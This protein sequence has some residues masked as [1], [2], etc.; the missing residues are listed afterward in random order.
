MRFEVVTAVLLRITVPSPS[1]SGSSKSRRF[2]L[3]LFDPEDEGTEI[4]PHV[5]NYMASDVMS[6][7]TQICTRNTT[8]K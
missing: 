6:L 8:V 4:L 3:D 1:P 7:K 5:R 2:F